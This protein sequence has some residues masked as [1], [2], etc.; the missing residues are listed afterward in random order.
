MARRRYFGVSLA[1]ELDYP[2]RGDDAL[3]TMLIGGGLALA[4]AAI[5]IV[6]SVLTFVLIGF[7][8]LPFAFVPQILV[9]GYLFRVLGT[10]LD[11]DAEPPVWE[12]WE[13]LFVDGLKL[14][15]VVIAY[16]LP[17]VVVSGV[18]FVAVFVVSSVGAGAGGDAGGALAGVGLVVGLVLGLLTVVLGLGVFYVLPIGLCGM[19]QDDALGG[20]FDLGR[21]REVGTSREYAV[22][23]AVGAAVFVVGGGVAQFL[24]VLLV[25]FPLRFAT[26]ALGFRYFA[27]GYADA[28]GVDVAPAGAETTAA[29]AGTPADPDPLYDDTEPTTGAGTDTGTTTDADPRDADDTDA[30]GRD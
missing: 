13:D 17:V 12:D 11:G 10:T 21:L 25:G 3:V 26:Q 23:W 1:D 27:R 30:S 28:L 29:G 16:T 24:F 6:G 18:L 15:A 14:V 2:L 19:A 8:L 5:S 20:A 9:Q 7:L 22:A 4:A